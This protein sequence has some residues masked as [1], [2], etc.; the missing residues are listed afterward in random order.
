M[1]FKQALATIFGSILVVQ[2]LAHLSQADVNL[3]GNVLQPLQ[4][5]MS[6]VSFDYFP[7]FDYIDGNFT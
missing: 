6:V 1:V 2:L 7:P 3:P 5:M 4:V